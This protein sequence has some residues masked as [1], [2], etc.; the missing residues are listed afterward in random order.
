M[1]L[2]KVSSKFFTP[3]QANASPR[4][5]IYITMLH[6]QSSLLPFLH[7]ELTDTKLRRFDKKAEKLNISVKISKINLILAEKLTPHLFY[8]V[9]FT[10]YGRQD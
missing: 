2:N 3:S 8:F 1:K 10:R 6:V 7:A 4:L 5:I 9:K